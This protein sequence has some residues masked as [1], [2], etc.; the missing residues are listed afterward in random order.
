[1]SDVAIL[2][3]GAPTDVLTY[4]ND[5]ARTGQNLTEVILLTSAI[6]GLASS[7]FIRWTAWSTPNRS[8]PRMSR[9][10]RTARTI[11]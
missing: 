1:M 10:R 6:E 8:T 2:T 7:A 4:H 5:N 9:F 11:C 3:V